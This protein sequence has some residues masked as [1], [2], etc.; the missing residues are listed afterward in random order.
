M[1]TVRTP[2]QRGRKETVTSVRE[3]QWRLDDLLR[4]FL[5]GKMIF[6]QKAFV[7]DLSA[8]KEQIIAEFEARVGSF[9][10]SLSADMRNQT[11]QPFLKTL[12]QGTVL[13]EVARLTMLLCPGPS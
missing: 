12:A 13:E 4:D 10:D 2:V 3:I 1:N 9:A 8:K 5:R 11:V 6:N 7:S